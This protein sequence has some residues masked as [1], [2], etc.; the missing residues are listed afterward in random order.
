MKRKAEII[1][2]VTDIGLSKKIE[3]LPSDIMR[4]CRKAFSSIGPRIKA[5]TKGAGS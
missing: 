5:N 4:D 3:N 2:H 1:R